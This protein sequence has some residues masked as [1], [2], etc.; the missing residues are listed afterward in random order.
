MTANVE[1]G[2]VARRWMTWAA[3]AALALS[4]G[5]ARG[6]QVTA[7]AEPPAA[8][9]PPT[10]TA[11][12][13]R[14][15]LLAE[16][17][18][19]MLIE[20]QPALATHAEAAELLAMRWPVGSPMSELAL[21]ADRVFIAL[22]ASGGEGVEIYAVLIDPGGSPFAAYP[23][24]RVAAF[25]SDLPEDDARAKRW[26]QRCEALAAADPTPN[27]SLTLHV[28]GTAGAMA[29]VV[30]EGFPQPELTSLTVDGA[31]ADERTRMRVLLR[32]ADSATAQEVA[33]AASRRVRDGA[34]ADVAPATV[35]HQPGSH[36]VQVEHRFSMDLLADGPG[37]AA[38]GDAQARPPARE[39]ASG[40]LCP[41]DTVPRAD[42]VDVNSADL[43]ALMTLPGIGEQE[44]Q[45]IIDNRRD[46][47]PALEL[48]ELTG[49]A[50]ALTAEQVRA[51]CGHAVTVVPEAPG[52][53]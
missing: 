27:R 53:P 49:E 8:D 16:P 4:A 40:E 36:D 28:T 19:A 48:E 26:A 22:L 7:T 45:A 41:T 33:A 20:L 23:C 3:F 25:G 35:H 1:G 5:C 12:G 42:A 34:F 14:R 32:Y 24:P 51:L 2:L 6:G 11:E 9:E 13:V 44:A 43:K 17:G 29:A 15:A 37:P 46:Y 50:G 18:L 10:A 47:G 38:P 31:W 21:T 52:G 30:P 39:Y